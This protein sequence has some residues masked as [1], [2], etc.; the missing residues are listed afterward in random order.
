MP[1]ATDEQLQWIERVATY[2]ARDGMPPIAGRVLGWLMISEPAEQSAAEI[3]AAVG[4]SRASLT[5]TLRLLM[6]AGFVT[7]QG[8]AG[9]RTAYYRIDDDAWG[10]VVRAQ[11]ASIGTFQSIAED[12]LRLVG[13]KSSRREGLNAASDVFAWMAEVFENAPPMPRRDGS[14]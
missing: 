6:A 14:R 5:T 10:R 7:R 1:T 3:A 9:E 8:R 2:L 13:R 11:V 12:G 4:A